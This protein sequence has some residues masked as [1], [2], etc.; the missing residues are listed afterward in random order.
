MSESPNPREANRLF[1]AGLLGLSVAVVIQLV[2]K[3]ELNTSQLVTVYAYAVA[4]P[5]LAAGLIADY[6]SVSGA[7]VPRWMDWLGILGGI[8][9]VVGLGA[10]FFHFGPGVGVVFTSGCA[11][12]FVL[13]RLL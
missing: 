11:V 5:L 8:A 6:A 9:A 10:V 13:I 2:D 4:M 3:D 12:V 7:S 1:Y